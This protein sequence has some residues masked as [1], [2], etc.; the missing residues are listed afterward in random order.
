MGVALVAWI[1]PDPPAVEPLSIGVCHGVPR[2]DGPAQRASNAPP[3]ACIIGLHD[4]GFIRPPK[5]RRAPVGIG[6]Q[7]ALV[8]RRKRRG[9]GVSYD[10]CRYC[11]HPLPGYPLPFVAGAVL[12]RDR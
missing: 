6:D 5:D 4:P 1:D 9:N 12:A 2:V 11:S 8:E 7:P 3:Q 10:L